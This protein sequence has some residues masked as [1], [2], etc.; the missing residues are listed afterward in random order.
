MGTDAILA[1]QGRSRLDI[2]LT[3]FPGEDTKSSRQY[4]HQGQMGIER[5]GFGTLY[6]EAKT[7]FIHSAQ[8]WAESAVLPLLG[9]YTSETDLT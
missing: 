4:V 1:Q 3:T 8:C 9:Y 6:L 7:E 2:T 5:N